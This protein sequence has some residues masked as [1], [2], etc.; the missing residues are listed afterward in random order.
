MSHVVLSPNPTHQDPD[1]PP[2]QVPLPLHILPRKVLERGRG[3]VAAAAVDRDEPLGAPFIH[4][5]RGEGGGDLSSILLIS[6][7]IAAVTWR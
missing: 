3:A 5:I 4:D 7:V 1:L 2:A 6:C